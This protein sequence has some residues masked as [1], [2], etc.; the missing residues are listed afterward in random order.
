MKTLASVAI[1]TLATLLAGCAPTAA[2]EGLQ[3]ASNEASQAQTCFYTSQITGYRNASNSS[4]LVTASLGRTFEA[5]FVGPCP[6]M[7]PTASITIKAEKAVGSR[8]C[9]GDYA[10]LNTYSLGEGNGQCRIRV[11]RLL[12][13]EEATA[14]L[15]RN[16]NRQSGVT[17]ANAP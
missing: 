5:D 15:R 6:E 7:T 12:S 13:E 1:L 4:L 8:L 17:G 11:V 14:S 3:L 9:G 10:S 2:P 16:M